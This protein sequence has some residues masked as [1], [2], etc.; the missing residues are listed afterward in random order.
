MTANSLCR[1]KKSLF[2]NQYIIGLV[3]FCQTFNLISPTKIEYLILSKCKTVFY[4][5][6]EFDSTKNSYKP[7]CLQSDSLPQANLQ[8]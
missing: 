8:I 6:Q 1:V 4:Q 5:N 7:C 3:C 2:V